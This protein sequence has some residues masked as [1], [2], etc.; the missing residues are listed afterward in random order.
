MTSRY[1]GYQEQDHHLVG[2]KKISVCLFIRQGKK[3]YL[4]M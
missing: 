2:H 3:K 1:L 4:Q